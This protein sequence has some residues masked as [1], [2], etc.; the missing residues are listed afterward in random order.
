[1]EAV[2]C[3]LASEGS[4]AISVVTTAAVKVQQRN[5]DGTRLLVSGLSFGVDWS[6]E[7]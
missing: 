3:P 5:L 7:V 2:S 4:V 6:L 1:M